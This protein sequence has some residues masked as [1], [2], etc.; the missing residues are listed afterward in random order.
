MPQGDRIRGVETREGVSQIEVSADPN[1][2]NGGA[3]VVAAAGTLAINP[4]STLMYYNT[5]GTPTGWEVFEAGGAG[6]GEI[7]T[8]AN[9][10]TSGGESFRD[11]TGVVLNFR[12]VRG[13]DP[14]TGATNGDYIDVGLDFTTLALEATPL[15]ADEILFRKA[16]NDT[17]FRVTL[18]DVLKFAGDVTDGLSVG[19]GADVYKLKS[20][21]VLHFRSVLATLPVAVSEGTNELTLSFTMTGVT[22]I[23]TP[24]V[25]TDLLILQ[26]GVAAPTQATV[27]DLPFVPLADA[28]TGVSLGGGTDIYTGMVGT[29]LQFRSITFATD[30]PVKWSSTASE[31]DFQFHISSATPGTPTSVD[32]IIY[33]SFTDGK[34]YN[35]DFSEVADILPFVGNNLGTGADVYK[36]KTG[37]TLHFRSLLVAASNTPLVYSE[38]TNEIQL[39]FDIEGLTLATE[40]IGAD[41]ILVKDA[42]TNVHHYGTVDQLPFGTGDGTITGGISLGT[43]ADIFIG[44][45][46]N[47][48]QFR[49]IAFEIPGPIQWTIASNVIEFQFHISGA[50]GGTPT[51]NDFL[52]YESFTDGL[53]YHADIGEIADAMPFT[54]L[55]LGTGRDVYKTKSG[56]TLQFRS[57]IATLPI[58]N[59]ENANDITFTFNLVG[60]GSTTVQGTD[61]VLVN[62]AGTNYAVAAS[63]FLAATPQTFGLHWRRTTDINLPHNTTTTITWNNE[64]RDTI[65]KTPGST[66]TPGTAGVY[67]INVMIGL[68]GLSTEPIAMQVFI[69]KNGVEFARTRLPAIQSTSISRIPLSHAM[70]FSVSDYLTVKINQTNTLS[71]AV[72]V[73]EA[74]LTVDLLGVT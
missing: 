48:L 37:S 3:G 14:I 38:L 60:L 64:V 34:N 65:G 52:I 35:A 32:H 40:I 72:T 61:L 73:K 21:S 59:A 56:T 66:L 43:G 31:I 7:N 19:T 46:S 45:V 50:T 18:S 30:S 74:Y 57:L 13:V 12:R 24:V 58:V 16:S 22:P 25:G 20:G 39:D 69:Y 8:G 4:A 71:S 70:L 17:Y 63:T 10:G 1:T 36:N 47:V 55:S 15:D 53:N 23:A 41:S 29:V 2:L 49:T 51:G 9:V 33:E 6:T 11:K 27:A 28:A 42:T 62:R 54:G 67:Q 44:E 5:N 26:R 68:T